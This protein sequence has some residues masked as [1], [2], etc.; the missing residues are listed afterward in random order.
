MPSFVSFG[1]S[2][3]PAKLELHI[4]VVLPFTPY[5]IWSIL[6]PSLTHPMSGMNTPSRP[7]DSSG[8]STPTGPPIFDIDAHS[9]ASP[10]SLPEARY[11]GAPEFNQ[12][13]PLAPL[14][15]NS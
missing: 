3:A 8:M 13:F 7:I 10:L 14:K 9:P 1:M 11:L 5:R 15:L 12:L 4:G 2:P 6:L